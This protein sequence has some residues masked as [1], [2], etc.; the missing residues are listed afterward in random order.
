[1]KKNIKKSEDTDMRKE[2][3]FSGGIRGKYYK[4]YMEGTNIVILDPDVAKIF[5][6]SKIV[7]DTLRALARIAQ[8]KV[9]KAG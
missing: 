1:M 3:D 2:Y 9:K 8:K 4:R 6:D 7:N 5:P